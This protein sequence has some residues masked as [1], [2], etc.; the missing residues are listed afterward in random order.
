MQ[1]DWTENNTTSSNQS[2]FPN[3]SK[4]TIEITVNRI[5]TTFIIYYK[6]IENDSTSRYA[7]PLLLIQHVQRIGL[8]GLT[9]QLQ[10]NGFVNLLRWL[11]AQR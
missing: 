3:S 8:I 11:I 6:S 7:V 2:K 10:N 9:F 1:L 5:S 4:K